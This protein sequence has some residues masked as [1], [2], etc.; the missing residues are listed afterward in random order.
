MSFLQAEFELAGFKKVL[1]LEG[2]VFSKKA[3]VFDDYSWRD[4]RCN[5]CKR[6]I[7]CVCVAVVIFSLSYLQLTISLLL[8][9]MM[10]IQVGVLP[11]RT[12]AVYQH[13]AGGV[14]HSQESPGKTASLDSGNGTKG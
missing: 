11:R 14:H 4:I 13:A 8:L 10:I 6:H 1:G 3:T 2:E 12:A 9:M 5:S 7:G